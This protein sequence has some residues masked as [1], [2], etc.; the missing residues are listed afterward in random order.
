VRH[1]I[2]IDFGFGNPI[3]CH[4]LRFTSETVLF[5]IKLFKLPVYHVFEL[6]FLF[7]GVMDSR[8]DILFRLR[9][10]VPAIEAGSRKLLSLVSATRTRFSLIR[11]LHSRHHNSSPTQR[12]HD[13]LKDLRCDRANVHIQVWNVQLVHIHSICHLD[14]RLTPLVNIFKHI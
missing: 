2:A 9:T 11:P 3:C 10:L 13:R 4:Y 12:R 8:T 7:I 1:I 14:F 5:L 6:S